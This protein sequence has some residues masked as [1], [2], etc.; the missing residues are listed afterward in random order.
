VAAI[1]GRVRA[2]GSISGL[3]RVFH[4][5][6]GAV[7]VVADRMDVLAGLVYPYLPHPLL[8]GCPW[9]GIQALADDCYLLV[10]RDRPARVVRWW[11][12]PEPVLPLAEAAPIVAQALVTAVEA[13]TRAGGT[14]SADLSGGLDSTPLCFLATRGNARVIALTLAGADTG[15]DDV[16]WAERAA[17]HL[18]GVEHL[19]FNLRQLPA[20][21]ED[22][23]EAGAGA[24]EPHI[25]VRDAASTTVV[26]R[27]LIKRGSRLHL[28]GL[29][30]DQVLLA[31]I[32]YLH[33]TAWTHP[34]IAADHLRGR[35]ATG[36]WP[37]VP[38]LRG[39]ADRRTYRQWLAASI[40][41]L[42][43]PPPTPGRP[44]L[45]WGPALRLPPWASAQAADAARSLLRQ[46]AA[47]A[48]PLAPTRGQHATLEHL[49]ATGYL[50]RHV[51]T[52]MARAGLPLA[53]PFLDDRVVEACLAVRPYERT[54]PWRYK[55][56]IVEAMRDL[57]PAAVLQRTTK[58]NFSADGARRAA[59]RPRPLGHPARR[60]GPGSSRPGRR[61]RPARGLPRPVPLR[62]AAGRTRPD[63]GLRGMAAHP[64]PDRSHHRDRSATMTV[65]LRTDVSTT[66]TDEGLVLLDE[67]AGRYWQL[68]PTGALVLRLLLHGATPQQVAQTLADRYAVSAEQAAAD[69]AA[70]L[71]RLHTAG[72]VNSARP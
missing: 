23:G 27:Q 40:D 71:Q 18:D 51:A 57:V 62:P 45:G 54:T 42:M 28:G 13:H 46:A 30:G 14:I 65:R 47:D 41:G 39:L 6:V 59:P 24:D 7:T 72:L 19:I 43:A 52:I 4:T 5:Q 38:T 16:R 34:R 9:Q 29:G 1:D 67:R 64:T 35:R 53:A 20:M 31:P 10:D 58:G 63:P 22:V 3:R 26:A 32:P 36:G 8:D 70:L 55:P 21:Y 56:L 44:N 11:N 61:R 66:D 50:T 49:R 69:V 12:P 33:T 25:I 48:Q 15:H 17:R 68:N 37:L 2:Q 60:P